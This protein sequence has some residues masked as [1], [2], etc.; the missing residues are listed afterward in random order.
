MVND[1][2]DKAYRD[3]PR[4]F[5]NIIMF[6]YRR[7]SKYSNTLI[8]ADDI[9][10]WLIKPGNIAYWLYDEAAMMMLCFNIEL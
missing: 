3:S 5:H 2:Y 4:I 9:Y 10:W 8:N 1:S 7:T 6:V